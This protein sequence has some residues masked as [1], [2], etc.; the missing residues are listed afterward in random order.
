MQSVNDHLISLLPMHNI[1]IYDYHIR[2]SV[3]ELF[4]KLISEYL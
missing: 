3:I 4:K 2:T 1:N